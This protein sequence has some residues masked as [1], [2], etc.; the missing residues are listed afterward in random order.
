VIRYSSAPSDS[1]F[2]GWQA[3]TRAAVLPS[4]AAAARSPPPQQLL[5]TAPSAAAPAAKKAHR[6]RRPSPG[7]KK[8]SNAGTHAAWKIASIRHEKQALCG[9][10]QRRRGVPG[11]EELERR[12][13]AH[14]V[15]LAKALPFDDDKR[16]KRVFDEIYD[17]TV[18]RGVKRKLAEAADASIKKPKNECDAEHEETPTESANA[19]APS[20]EWVRLFGAN[21]PYFTKLSL[22]G[23]GDDDDGDTV[24]LTFTT[25]PDE[26]AGQIVAFLDGKTAATVFKLSSPSRCRAMKK[27]FFKR[28]IDVLYD[29][30]KGEDRRRL[31]P[32]CPRPHMFDAFLEHN[33]DWRDVYTF[34]DSKEKSFFGP[35]NGAVVKFGLIFQDVDIVL[36]NS[37]YDVL[38]YF[39]DEGWISVNGA[40]RHVLRELRDGVYDSNNFATFVDDQSETTIRFHPEKQMHDRGLV[41]SHTYSEMLGAG[42]GWS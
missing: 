33:P 15:E 37:R 1:R 34:N 28:N 24:G 20:L 26:A 36:Q 9:W 42:S 23:G 27:V 21:T 30:I 3:R 10:I 40:E 7:S 4:K 6:R 29:S 32:S 35:R 17:R 16:S 14:V 2:E 39:L 19:T 8:P 11:A 13:R 22:G 12:L 31:A 18:K 41:I 25:L 5:T 38:K